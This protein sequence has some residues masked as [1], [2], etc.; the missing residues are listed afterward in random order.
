MGEQV[1]DNGGENPMNLVL[2]P[3]FR[4]ARGG[5]HTSGYRDRGQRSDL[6]PRLI[7][8]SVQAIAGA[9]EAAPD[10]SDPRLRKSRNCP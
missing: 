9:G 3:A 10:G 1:R 2:Q 6:R 7:G 5:S 4:A 8:A